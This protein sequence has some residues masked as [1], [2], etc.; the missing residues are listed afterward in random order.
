M[1]DYF[2]SVDLSNTDFLLAPLTQSKLEITEDE[3]SQESKIE[4]AALEISNLESCAFKISKVQ[5]EFGLTQPSAKRA[6]AMAGCEKK[7]L[8][9]KGFKNAIHIYVHKDYTDSLSLFEKRKP[10]EYRNTIEEEVCI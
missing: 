5:E 8:R 6:L 2:H 10:N 9:P 7:R 4:Q 3:T 1:C